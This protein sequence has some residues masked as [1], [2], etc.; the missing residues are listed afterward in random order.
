MSSKRSLY[1]KYIQVDMLKEKHQQNFYPRVE[2][3]IT[4]TVSGSRESKARSASRA[5]L[6]AG[7]VGPTSV[8]AAAAVGVAH[9]VR[10][11][12]GCQISISSDIQAEKEKLTSS[13]SDVS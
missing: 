2:Q 1:K 5:L 11:I 13:R 9:A 8:A 6:T 10:A 12:T 4:E 7:S 3:K